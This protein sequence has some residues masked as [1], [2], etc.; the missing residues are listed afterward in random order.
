MYDDHTFI[1]DL[2]TIVSNF[3]VLTDNLHQSYALYTH[4]L[5]KISTYFV[6]ILFSCFSHL[7]TLLEFKLFN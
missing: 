4:S 3:V 6:S 7:I 1:V 5:L 2:I